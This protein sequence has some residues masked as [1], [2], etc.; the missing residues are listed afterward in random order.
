MLTTYIQAYFII[1]KKDEPISDAE[2]LLVSGCVMHQCL[3]CECED[4]KNTLKSIDPDFLM[5]CTRYYNLKKKNPGLMFKMLVED[6]NRDKI[7][8]SLPELY[9]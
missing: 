7:L 4:C 9:Q 6:W 8:E 2:A 5:V 3:R 1:D